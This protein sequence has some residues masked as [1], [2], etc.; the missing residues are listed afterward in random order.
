MFLPLLALGEVLPGEM[1]GYRNDV[2]MVVCR[3][4]NQVFRFHIGRRIEETLDAD[5]LGMI[6][7]KALGDIRLLIQIDDEA[8]KAAFLTN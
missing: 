7:Q 1:A 5:R 3:V 8:A 6:G 2:D 4:A